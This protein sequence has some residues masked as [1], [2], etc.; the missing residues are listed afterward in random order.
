MAAKL[1]DGRREL[2]DKSFQLRIANRVAR[3]S[4]YIYL[5]LNSFFSL[6]LFFHF[7]LS[8]CFCFFGRVYFHDVIF[9]YGPCFVCF[10]YVR[11]VVICSHSLFPIS[12]FFNILWSHCPLIYSTR[13]STLFKF[14]SIISLFLSY[15]VS[16]FQ[17]FI[18]AFFFTS[19]CSFYFLSSFVLFSYLLS[20]FLSSFIFASFLFFQ[21]SF[22]ISF[23]LN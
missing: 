23:F 7:C 17:T 1:E 9:S 5:F 16:S 20:E 3:K 10:L 11:F 2:A 8:F 19:F 4:I 21:T 14:P 18:P 15:R 6:F 22:S 12:T 13:F